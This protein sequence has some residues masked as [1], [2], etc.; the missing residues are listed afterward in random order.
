MFGELP[1]PDSTSSTY[2]QCLD[3]LVT[4]VRMHRKNQVLE[5]YYSKIHVLSEMYS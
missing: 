4:P 5:V 2:T 1:E 3:N